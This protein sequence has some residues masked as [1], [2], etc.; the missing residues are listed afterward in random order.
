MSDRQ[1][2][3]CKFAFKQS[4]VGT[5][6]SA[7]IANIYR[8]FFPDRNSALSYFPERLN[9][10]EIIPHNHKDAPRRKRAIGKWR[11]TGSMARRRLKSTCCARVNVEPNAAPTKHENTDNIN[12]PFVSF[13]DCV[14]S[15]IVLLL[16]KERRLQCVTTEDFL[17]INGTFISDFLK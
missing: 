15:C 7:K 9:A 5:T 3:E 13:T 17:Q 6:F 8:R 16:T 10:A 12:A 14:K 2:V 11:V 1:S 4:V